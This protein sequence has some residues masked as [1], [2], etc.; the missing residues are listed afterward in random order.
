MKNLIKESVIGV[1]IGVLASACAYVFIYLVAGEQDFAN[2]IEILKNWNIFI[3]QFVGAMLTGATIAV[4]MNLLLR[5]PLY[6][7]KKDLR[8]NLS[9]GKIAGMTAG[10]MIALL[11]VISVAYV[12]ICYMFERSSDLFAQSFATLEL[13]VYIGYT[14]SIIIVN[15][16]EI[17]GINKVV[18]KRNEV[19]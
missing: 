18:A 3:R 10:L 15:K 2:E 14:L 19:K 7:R 6:V 17:K 4:F 8:N 11:A 5:I 12:G 1:L 16:N 9:T 13:L